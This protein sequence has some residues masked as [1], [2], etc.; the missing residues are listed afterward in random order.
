MIRFCLI[1]F[2]RKLRCKETLFECP[3]ICALR[4]LDFRLSR[5]DFILIVSAR[6][7]I[8]TFCFGKKI[9]MFCLEIR[10]CQRL[11]DEEFLFHS[12]CCML[13]L[14]SV[15]SKLSEQ[16]AYIC[17]CRDSLR[18]LLRR[19]RSIQTRLKPKF[20]MFISSS[21]SCRRTVFSWK[22]KPFCPCTFRD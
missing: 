7:F 16:A 11:A 18:A 5:C 6:K 3:S 19:L 21:K 20:S 15:Q 2:E 12:D 1:E 8:F 14:S 13:R 9:R 22:K 10:V 4:S 17:L